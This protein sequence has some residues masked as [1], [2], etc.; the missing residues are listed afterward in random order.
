MASAQHEPEF[1][2]V[3][4]PDRARK[5]RQP[6]IDEHGDLSDEEVDLPKGGVQKRRLPVIDKGDDDLNAEELMRELEETT[7]ENTIS[8]E[9]LDSGTAITNKPAGLAQTVDSK[10]TI[11][12]L[13]YGQ[14]HLRRNASVQVTYVIPDFT[15]KQSFGAGNLEFAYAFGCI[16]APMD[17]ILLEPP[18]QMTDVVIR[19][20]EMERLLYRKS[21]A[22]CITVR[23]GKVAAF[24]KD[25]ISRRFMLHNPYAKDP[26]KNLRTVEEEDENDDNSSPDRTIRVKARKADQPKRRVVTKKADNA[27]DEED[28]TKSDEKGSTLKVAADLGTNAVHIKLPSL[29]YRSLSLVI[30]HADLS[31]RAWN[32]VRAMTP[33]LYAAVFDMPKEKRWPGILN[34]VLLTIREYASMFP[35][36]DER[37]KAHARVMAMIES[38]KVAFFIPPS[39]VI[40]VL[41]EITYKYARKN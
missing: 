18:F 33:G 15:T 5:R 29:L 38:P 34:D 21:S 6:I 2:K 36:T 27:E 26:E 30:M 23:K 31:L 35:A 28:D 8:R 22:L 11:F 40:P 10:H 17:R 16:F 14:T 20:G 39:A 41:V 12:G 37:S 7:S 3:D 19:E 25:L 9:M 24:T 1:R 13:V 32:A 4:S